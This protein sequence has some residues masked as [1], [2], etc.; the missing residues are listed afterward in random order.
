MLSCLVVK[1]SCKLKTLEIKCF[2]DVAAQFGGHRLNVF[3]LFSIYTNILQSV[4]YLS[5]NE[6]DM[7][8]FLSEKC[9]NFD[10]FLLCCKSPKSKMI[11]SIKKWVFIVNEQLFDDYLFESDM[12][13]Y[14]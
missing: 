9:V 11:H 13:L 6:E 7:V 12:A 4:V 10:N 3:F 14:K 8:V 2:K 5:S 1:K